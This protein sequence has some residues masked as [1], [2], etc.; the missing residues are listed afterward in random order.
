MKHAAY[1]AA[2]D[3]ALGVYSGG[4][5]SL[6][7]ARQR[8]GARALGPRTVRPRRLDRVLRDRAPCAPPGTWAPATTSSTPTRTS[9]STPRRPLTA[10][11]TR[12]RAPA[13]AH[14]QHMY[15]HVLPRL[16]RW[17]EALAQFEKADAIEEA[18]AKAENLRPGDDWHHLH[19]L[20]LLGYTYLRLGRF[21]DAERTFRRAFD[22]PARLP[23]RG[24]AQASLAELY[25][26]R[27]RPEEALAVALALQVAD[28]HA[29]RARRRR[30]RRG[31]GA[32]RAGPRSGG[33]G[34]RPQ[35]RGASRERQGR[36]GRAG[37]VHGDLPAALRRPA[38]HGARSA[39]RRPVRGR[40]VDSEGGRRALR[41]PPFRRL[42]RRP[43][44]SGTDR[45]R[46]APRGSPGARRRH[47]RTD[48]EDRPGL[49]A[50]EFPFQVSGS[51]KDTGTPGTD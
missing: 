23:Y 27:G 18:Y 39:R 16:S 3:S 20:Q 24:A 28:P 38:R 30:G 7:P 41:Q 22:T 36:G 8:G 40:G 46:G 29:R 6:D 5:R 45:G 9:G 32:A 13:V 42:G 48:E 21:D 49:H 2:L 10:R 26:L 50:G 34:G 47:H 33:A 11:S 44:P 12:P 17:D 51:R 35:G 14:A 43:L 25:L 31:R 37:P 19:N 1:K 4:C 15:G